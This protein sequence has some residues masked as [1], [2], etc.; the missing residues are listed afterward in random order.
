[1]IHVAQRSLDTVILAIA[2]HQVHI[3]IG[4][5]NDG[6]DAQRTWQLSAFRVAMDTVSSLSSW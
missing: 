5:Q 1:M 4:K 2:G 3:S 6:L